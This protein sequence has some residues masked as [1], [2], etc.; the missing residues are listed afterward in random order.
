MRIL[1]SLTLAAAISVS[2]LAVSGSALAVETPIST[3]YATLSDYWTYITTSGKNW[4][5][6]LGYFGGGSTK[7]NPQVEEAV[8]GGTLYKQ[9]TETVSWTLR[10]TANTVGSVIT[11]VADGTQIDTSVATGFVASTAYT[12]FATPSTSSSVGDSKYVTRVETVP[13]PIAAAGLPFAAL[14]GGLALYRRRQAA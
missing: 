6:N 11:Y 13:G 2:P 3:S 8:T 4:W 12:G 9:V 5:D 7:V 1:R 14:L 10:I